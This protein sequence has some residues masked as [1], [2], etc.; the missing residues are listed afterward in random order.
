MTRATECPKCGGK[1]LGIGRHTGYSVMYPENKMSFGSDI[2]Y[3]ICTDCGYIIEGYVRKPE[4]FKGTKK[5]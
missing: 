5:N 2:D 4:K 1:E 3:V